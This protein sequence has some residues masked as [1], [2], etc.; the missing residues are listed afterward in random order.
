MLKKHPTNNEEK[1][2]EKERE[3]RRG[4]GRRGKKEG[5]TKKEKVKKKKEV[6]EVKRKT[7]EDWILGG[8]IHAKKRH[9]SLSLSLLFLFFL[10]VC[11]LFSSPLIKESIPAIH[12][13]T[14]QS[15][16]QRT[17]I[18]RTPRTPLTLAKKNKLCFQLTNEKKKGSKE[19]EEGP[20]YFD[21]A[22]SRAALIR[23]VRVR[24]G[25]ERLKKGC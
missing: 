20:I 4:G 9:G 8:I 3:E 16:Q 7:E 21:L 10:R 2:V 23:G 14:L 15:S 24:S 6:K 22:S 12:I 5:R 1:E 11:Y 25:S 13:H 19:E 17:T 18:S